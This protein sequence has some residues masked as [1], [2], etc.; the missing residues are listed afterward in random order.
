MRI[1][2]VSFG[3]RHGIPANAQFVFDVRRVRNPFNRKELRY[4]TGLDEE[5]ARFV[6]R[7][8][9]GHET[10]WAIVGTM[11]QLA[12]GTHAHGAGHAIVVG[13]GCTGGHHRSVAIA[14]ALAAQFQDYEDGY[15]AVAI[16][17]DLENA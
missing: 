2:F 13:V 15:D 8:P 6:L 7:S 11:R 14:Q 10:L 5:T 12:P 16:H 17:R 3:Y 1:E 4:T 9:S